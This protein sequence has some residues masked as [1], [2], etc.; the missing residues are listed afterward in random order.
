L[1]CYN[2][3]SERSAALLQRLEKRLKYG[4][5]FMEQDQVIISRDS[6]AEAQKDFDRKFV[7]SNALQWWINL[8]SRYP[9]AFC[10][11]PCQ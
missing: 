5:K 11:W 6:A 3:I 1:L 8:P 2:F 9:E 10:V 7:C 4:Y